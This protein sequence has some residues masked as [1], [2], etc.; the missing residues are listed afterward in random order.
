MVLRVRLPGRPREPLRLRP[1]CFATSSRGV[2]KRCSHGSR[3]LEAQGAVEEGIGNA[4]GAVDRVRRRVK[5][6]VDEARAK[7]AVKRATRAR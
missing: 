6:R 1:P 3:G 7:H 2:K 5:A 4:E